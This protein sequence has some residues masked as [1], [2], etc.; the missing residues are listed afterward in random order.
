MVLSSLASVDV[1][2]DVTTAMSPLGRARV[3]AICIH[4]VKFVERGE[5]A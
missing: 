2:A 1:S 5:A 3:W 4:V